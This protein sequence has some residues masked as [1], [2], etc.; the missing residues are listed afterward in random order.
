MNSQSKIITKQY[1]TPCGEMILGATE[2][3]LCLCDWM[4]GWHQG[5]TEGRLCRMLRA[6]M[7]EGEDPVI[8]Q[9]IQQLE[10]YFRRERK[11]FTVPLLAVGTDFQRQVWDT[12]MGI[13][14]G[15][16]ISYGEEARR[17]GRPSAV[18]AVANANG[19][20]PIAIFIPCHR[21]IGSDG[22]LI[23]YGGGMSVKEYLLNLE[24]N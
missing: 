8:D 9:A 1:N 15:E 21:V 7:V 17:M 18:R 13:G 12:L 22:S 3:K 4:G 10:E 2:G 11:T 16:Q 24:R 20:N 6:E 23:G 19:R 14:Y 5:E